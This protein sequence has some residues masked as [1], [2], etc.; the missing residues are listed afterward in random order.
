MGTRCAA[1]GS[2]SNGTDEGRDEVTSTASPRGNPGT[3]TNSTARPTNG[4]RPSI[5]ELV[6]S[7][8]EKLSQLIRDE[9]RLAKAELAEKAKHAAIGIGLMAVAAMLGFFAVA[10]LIA[11]A[12]LGL[13]NAVDAWLAALIVGLVLLI[14]AAVL[15]VVGK[16]ALDRGTPPVPELAQASIKADVAAVKEGLSS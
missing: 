15:V 1:H 5:G 3:S 6:G 2:R 14:V 10:V 16:K 13:A 11:S 12:I 4:T 7:L 9:I 8:S